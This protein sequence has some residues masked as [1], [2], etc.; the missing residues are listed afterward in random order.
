M[1]LLY[2]NTVSSDTYKQQ[3][4]RTI[5]YQITAATTPQIQLLPILLVILVLLILLFKV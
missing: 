3:P 1:Q 2:N 5:F 4:I